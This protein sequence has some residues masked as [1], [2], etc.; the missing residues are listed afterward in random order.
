MNP[1]HKKIVIFVTALMFA[2]CFLFVGGFLRWSPFVVDGQ[3]V[4]VEL[5]VTEG[6]FARGLGGR[7]RLCG[8][9]GM[10]FDFKTLQEPRF[11]MK[12]MRFDIDII[13]VRGGR[14][15]HIDHDVS[16]LTPTVLYE[17]GQKI[18]GVLELPAGSAGAWGV[19]VGDYASLWIR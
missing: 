3:L 11:W 8:R 5:P 4:F 16:H 1:F 10:Y 2:A 14:I 17:A 19:E 7:D 6:E 15:V 13:W 18:E 12:D 9:C